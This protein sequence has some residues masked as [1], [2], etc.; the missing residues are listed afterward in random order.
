MNFTQGHA[1]LIGIGTHQYHPGLDVPITVEDA[2]A[3]ATVLRDR[4]RCGYPDAQVKLLHNE[5]ATKAGILKALDDLAGQVHADDTV[6]LFYCGHGALGTDGNYYLVSHDA[7]LQG[8]RVVAGT[9]VSEGELLARLRAIPSERTL[10]IF[11]A[12]FSGN[13]SPTLGP[14][15]SALQTHNP[16]EET[17][18]AML[19]TGKGRII[20]VACGEDQYSYIGDGRQTI[21]TQALVDGLAGSGVQNQNGYISAFSLYQH[22]YEAVHGA[23]KRQFNKTQEPELTV[24]KGVGPFAVSLYKGASTLGEFDAGQDLPEDMAV[25]AVEPE[26]SAKY[27]SQRVIQTG[28]GAAVGGTVDT[29][30]DFTGRDTTTHGDKTGG[31]K[32]GRDKVSGVNFGNVSGGIHGSNIAGRDVTGKISHNEQSGGINFGSGNTIGS[33]GDIV[34]G[35]KSTGTPA[36]EVQATSYSLEEIYGHLTRTQQQIQAADP[37]LAQDLGDVLALLDAGIEARDEGKTARY[38]DKM[39]R[40]QEYLSD[41]A[42]SH[43][44]LRAVVAMLG[45]T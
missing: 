13:I 18:A 38:Q 20:V 27:F 24:L 8:Q 22:L 11:N 39:R 40:A 14:E 9:G 7:R 3:V 34:A 35:N 6:F 37:D 1:L 17:A 29:G 25:R 12:C 10:V 44:V 30:G 43:T 28:G 32:V 36:R 23:V 19:G 4:A 41:L 31:D 42:E 16:T 2:N 26:V 15:A 21:F 45:K 33:T 5:R